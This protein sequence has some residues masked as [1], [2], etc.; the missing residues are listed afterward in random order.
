MRGKCLPHSI[1]SLRI[2][3]LKLVDYWSISSFE[4]EQVTINKVIY[5]VE[6]IFDILKEIQRSNGDRRPNFHQI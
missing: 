6:T 1:W 2:T 3:S 4:F 5:V